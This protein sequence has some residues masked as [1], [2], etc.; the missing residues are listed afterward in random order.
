MCVY[1]CIY[2]HIYICMNRHRNMNAHIHTSVGQKHSSSAS[3]GR[4]PA[5]PAAAPRSDL[6]SVVAWGH[7]PKGPK[8]PNMEY[9][10]FLYISNRN[11]G[12]GY[13]L[14]IWV[15]GPL[16][17]Y[18]CHGLTSLQEDHVWIISGLYVAL[19]EAL[20]FFI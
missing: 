3:A 19:L 17:Q 8:Y 10:W 13:I 12:L 6:V 9:I 4:D 11:Y 15:L 20:P 18:I 2:I 16:G 5:P 1:V 7:N 14:H